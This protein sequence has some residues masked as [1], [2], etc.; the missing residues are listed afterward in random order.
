LILR[1]YRGSIGYQSEE[2]L[3]DKEYI[4]AEFKKLETVWDKIEFLKDLQKLNLPYDINYEALIASW[5]LRGE[6]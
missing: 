3:M 6:K 1:E 2:S 4:F 5:E